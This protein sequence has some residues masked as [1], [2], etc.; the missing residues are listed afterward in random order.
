MKCK[1]WQAVLRNLSDMAGIDGFQEVFNTL[2]E[3]RVREDCQVYSITIVC[4]VGKELLSSTRSIA[5]LELEL[6]KTDGH[7]GF[8]VGS[9]LAAIVDK[10]EPLTPGPGRAMEE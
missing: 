9:V 5:A 4:R 1:V 10:I 6:C 8:L 3:V 2:E 7:I